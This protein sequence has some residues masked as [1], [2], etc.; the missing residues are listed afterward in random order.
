[1]INALVA[2]LLAAL[3]ASPSFAADVGVSIT[4]GQPG[5]Y[6]H[7][8]IG[9]APPPQIIYSRPVIVVQQPV[10]VAPRPIYL[11][12]QPGHE[13]NW[14]KHCYRYEACGYPVY[15]VRN[16]WYENVYV[17]HYREHRSDRHDRH[18]HR[19]RY[20]RDDRRH[21]DRDDRHGR[22]RDQGHGQG[23]GRRDD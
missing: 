17:P 13:K 23:R 1:M 14:R 9:Q 12:V 11:R 6:G 21:G 3:V 4:I 5:F 15:F 10:A 19:D 2:L 18:D 22:G 7:I 16:D 20:D 8:D